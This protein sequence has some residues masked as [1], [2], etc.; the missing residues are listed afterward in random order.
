MG[1][2]VNP[3]SLRLPLNKNWQSKWFA[4]KDFRK[5]LIADIRVRELINK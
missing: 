2:K 3:I 1:Q 5:N 4:T